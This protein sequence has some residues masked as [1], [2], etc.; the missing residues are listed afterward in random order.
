MSPFRVNRPTDQAI[1]PDQRMNPPT[2]SKSGAKRLDNIG[3]QGRIDAELI[4]QLHKQSPIGMVA[5]LVNSAILVFILWNLVGHQVLLLWLVASAAVT[6]LRYGLISGYRT[7]ASRKIQRQW[8]GMMHVVGFAVSGLVWGSAGLFLFPAESTAHQ[9]FIAFLLA[10]MVAGAVGTC[11]SV[12]AAFVA[13]SL[14]ALVPILIR[15][16]LIGVWAFAS[17]PF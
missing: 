10:G 9:A 5:T 1:S 16:L 7:A 3:D 8:L 14:P 15:F 6:V 2:G 11:S 17:S 4:D 13:F 12:F